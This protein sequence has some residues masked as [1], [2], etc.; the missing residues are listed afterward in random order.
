VTAVDLVQWLTAQ[1]DADERIAR[2]A[3]PSPWVDQGGYVTDVGP[4]G[5][6]RVQVTDYG[7]QDGEPEEDN[8]RGR[9]DSSH[10][11]RH[12]PARVLRETDAKRAIVDAYLPPGEDPHPGEPCINHEGQ[13]PAEYSGHDGCWRHLEASKR[14]LHHDY[15]LR[16]LASVYADRDGYRDEW[17]PTR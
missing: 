6:P 4:D 10:I 15:V 2:A 14:L 8:P 5:L 9:A 1:L 17:A 12:G 11:A 7:T 13:D 3:T 16:L